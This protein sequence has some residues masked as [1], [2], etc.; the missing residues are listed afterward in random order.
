MN[1]NLHIERLVLDGIA[2]DPHKIAD[3]KASVEAELSQL[4]ISQGIGSAMQSNYNCKSV[5]GVS[6]SMENISASLELGH[7]IGSAVYKGVTR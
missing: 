2:V 6:F 5:R 7:Q 3:L 1:I 4:L